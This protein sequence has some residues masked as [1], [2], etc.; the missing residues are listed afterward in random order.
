MYLKLHG[1][2]INNFV[3]MFQQIKFLYISLTIV[4]CCQPR[5]PPP[6]WGGCQSFQGGISI[7][8]SKTNTKLGGSLPDLFPNF[9]L[10]MLRF[11][12]KMLL[13]SKI[14]LV[15]LLLIFLKCFKIVTVLQA[16]L[17]YFL[18]TKAVLTPL[19]NQTR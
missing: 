8:E 4:S 2:Y 18:A 5:P 14:F 12:R 9:T 17:V 16:Q 7:G 15:H 19:L 11:L 13:I 3:A 10:I 6:S 1:T